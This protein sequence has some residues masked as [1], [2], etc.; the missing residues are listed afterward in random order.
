[1]NSI[2]LII[3]FFALMLFFNKNKLKRIII[4]FAKPLLLGIMGILVIKYGISLITFIISAGA[5]LLAL[6]GK[7]DFILSKI[8]WLEKLFP[9][10]MRNNRD[11]STHTPSNTSSKMSLHEAREIL[12]VNE[13]ANHEQIKKAYY[14]LML[15]NHPDQG[16]SKYFS[17]KINQAKDILLGR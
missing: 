3:A 13:N 2:I 5:I 11:N 7:I 4:K 17:A 10:V 9:H 6:T 1:M 8:S 14:N 16:G 12:G 15:K